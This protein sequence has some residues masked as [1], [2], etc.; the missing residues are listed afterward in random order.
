MK[1]DFLPSPDRSKSGKRVRQFRLGG[2]Q[3]FLG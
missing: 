1:K 3:N 2:V